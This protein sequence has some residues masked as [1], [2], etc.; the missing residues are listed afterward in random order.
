MVQQWA[1]PQVVGVL[2]EVKANERRVALTPSGAKAL[3]DDGQLIVVQA[4]AGLGS[5]FSDREYSSSTHRT[6][7]LPK[8]PCCST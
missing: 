6:K 5:G 3:L 4:G 7:F 2:S 8:R 1:L